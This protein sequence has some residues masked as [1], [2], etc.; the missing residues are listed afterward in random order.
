M[1]HNI[2]ANDAAAG[3][4]SSALA[5]GAFYEDVLPEVGPYALVSLPSGRHDWAANLGDLQAMVAQRIDQQGLYFGTASY[6]DSSSR[7]AANVAMLQALRLDID[8]G[9]EKLK[10]HGPDIRG[11][12]TAFARDVQD[13]DV[14]PTQRAA[15][16]RKHRH[17]RYTALGL[18]RMTGADATYHWCQDFGDYLP[19]F[20][21]DLA[22]PP[23]G[24]RLRTSVDGMLYRMA[25]I[26]GDRWR[27]GV[28]GLLARL[29][30]D[31]ITVAQRTVCAAQR[32]AFARRFAALIDAADTTNKEGLSDQALVIT[33]KAHAALLEEGASVADWLETCDLIADADYLRTCVTKA[34][35]KLRQG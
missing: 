16:W 13:P 21:G 7:K 10:K 3:K 15:R 25:Q 31:G 30:V 6:Q 29:E 18:E 11:I 23:K 27:A 35:E 9:P 33:R 24:R 32:E 1:T 8:A 19:A 17:E 4:R 20:A 12:D 5:W 2:V 22:D 34:C 26:F 14:S 28:D